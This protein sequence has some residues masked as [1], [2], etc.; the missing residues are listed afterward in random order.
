[1]AEVNAADL[2]EGS[3]VA[4]RDA[5]YLKAF[6]SRATNLP[7]VAAGFS[8]PIRDRYVDDLL[9]NGAAVL[10]HGYGDQP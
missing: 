7:W 4:T 8:T 5:V 9:R 3:V 1:M 10:R 6:E 2:P